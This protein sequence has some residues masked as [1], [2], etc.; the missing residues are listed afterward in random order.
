MKKIIITGV[1]G[2]DGS[3]MI[4]Y[5]L[6]N[7]SHTIIGGARRLSVK[8]HDNIEHVLDNPR[9]FLIDL[10][11]TDPQ[12]VDRVISEHKPDY[13]I[14]FAAN[15]FVGTSWKMPTQHMETNALGVLHQ[16]EAIK[17]HC[18]ECRYYNAGSSEEFGDV[19]TEPQTEEHPLRPRSPYGASKC[20][21]RHLVKVYRDSYDLYAVQGWLFNHEGVR[22]GTEFVTRKITQNVARISHQYAIKKSFK[23]LKLGNV[24]SKRD[25]SDSEDFMDGIWRMLNQE[26]Y[27]TNVW[28]SKPDEYVLSSDETHTIKEFVEEAFNC[29]GFHRSMCRW[30]G[31]DEDVK[32]YHGD[33]ILMEVDPKFYR[34]AEVDLLWGDS[35][36]IRE[37]LGWKPKTGFAGLVK[38]MVDN[39]LELVHSS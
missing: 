1:T 20:S 21:A 16:L 37:Q 12:N 27:W 19:I 22:R 10:D 28:K 11:V 3:N 7:T 31:I 15:S 18:P 13:F 5:L 38:K 30:E 2:Q 8:N 14:N 32:Y 33:D 6:K 17:R 24:E 25:W 26:E 9:F 36:K 34:P 39:D 35:S 4:D 23:P 29:A